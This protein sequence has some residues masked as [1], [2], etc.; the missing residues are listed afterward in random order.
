M[1][2]A[3]TWGPRVITL[4]GQMGAGKSTV[5]KALAGALSE[6]DTAIAID[7]D[8]EIA[9]AAGM[10]IPEIFATLG[11]PAFRALER[12]LLAAHL[13][14][15]E[16]VRVVA[17][18]GGAVCE[19]SAIAAALAAGPVIWLDAPPEVLAARALTP[20]RPLLAGRTAEEAA[21]FLAGQRATR[22]PFYARAHLHLDAAR[23]VPELVA[24]IVAR[25]FV[26]MSSTSAGSPPPLS[27]DALEVALPA[28]A[29]GHAYPIDFVSGPPGAVTAARIAERLPQTRRVL[30]VT[31]D[32]VASLHAAAF[33]ESLAASPGLSRVALHVVPAGEGTKSLA[34]VGAVCDAALEAGLTRRDALVALGGGV[35]GDLTGFAA[36]ILHRGVAFVQVPTTLLAQV[37]SSVGG[38]TGVN[39]AAGK[40]LLGAF[41]QPVAVI[42]SQSVLTT[43]PEREWRCG[44]AEAIKHGAI[45]DAA[46]FGWMAAEA[47]AILARDPATAAY[48]VRRCCEIKRDV[49]VRDPTEKGERALLNFGHTLGHAYER[50]LGYG[51]LTHGEAV[52]L[53]MIL[54][55]RVSERL[56]PP[57][58]TGTLE[59][60]LRALLTRFGFE[61]DVQAA[62][63]PGFNALVD[64]AAHDKKADASGTVRF[65]TLARLGEAAIT[66]LAFADVR[67]LIEEPEP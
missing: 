40:N 67:R 9:R 34:S 66:P 39:H 63:L 11:E 49:V 50:L 27:A 14:P 3:V 21:A 6:V 37:D 12:R 22:S 13:V 29:V 62:G 35:V 59:A 4:V 23:P 19:D 25:Y 48:L 10:P 28:P 30:V 17:T 36:S 24:E 47:D 44:L 1:S 46:L 45:A 60:P 65:I 8:A 18:G 15:G 43:L 57:E 20:D 54:A 61:V 41:W 26:G 5:A 52:A 42:S 33:V 32:H 7:L 58:L 56:G 53:G 38:K 55:A 16:A 64:A 51:H 2:G 31:D